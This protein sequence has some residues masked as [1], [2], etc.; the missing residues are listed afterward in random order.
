ML[1]KNTHQQFGADVPRLRFA[2]EEGPAF[3]ARYGWNP[4]EVHSMLKTAAVLKR[5]PLLMRILSL[6]PEDPKTGSR[7]WTGVC[8][9]G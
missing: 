7:P 5:L 1:Q 2:P 8:L 3:F 6:L 9:L 4:V